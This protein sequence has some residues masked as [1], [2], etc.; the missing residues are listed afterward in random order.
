M[1]LKWILL[2]S[3]HG[4]YEGDAVDFFKKSWKIMDLLIETITL[5]IWSIFEY[6]LF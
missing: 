3:T 4:K 1:W 5:K 6:V 2:Y